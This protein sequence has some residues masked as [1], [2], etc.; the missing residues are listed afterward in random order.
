LH[1]ILKLLTPFIGTIEISQSDGPDP[2]SDSSNDSVFGIQSVTKKET[3]V[4]SE[5]VYLHTPRSI[6][7][8]VRKSIGQCESELADGVRT[9][10]SNVVAADADGII[11]ADFFIDEKLLDVAH[12]AQ[13]KFC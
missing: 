1:M 2:A 12:H 6:I 10:F 4:G 11:I 3:E 8:N 5:G 7:L 13:S 9:C